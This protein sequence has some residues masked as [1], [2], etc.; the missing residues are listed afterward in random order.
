MKF[1][2]TLSA[3]TAAVMLCALPAAHATVTL[4]FS[5]DGG[6]AVTC[7]DQAA[8]D[9]NSAVGAVTFVGALGVYNVNVTTGLVAP[10]LPLPALIDMNSVN[11]SSAGVGAHTLTI[12]L[13][14]TG[15]TA[16]GN[17][18]GAFGGTLTGVGASVSATG[19]SGASLFALTNSLGT[20]GPFGAGAFSG[21]SN[22]LSPGG[23]YALTQV[24]NLASNGTVSYSGD[25]ELKVPEPGSLALA[26]LGLVALGSLRRRKQ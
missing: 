2:T 14:Q 7:A 22:G 21:T 16:P 17:I 1:R 11:V 23:T 18:T 19:Y 12:M 3:V 4:S 20:I 5:V 15:F 26:G 10:S 24:L 8:C 13:S 9:V 25:Y 6:A